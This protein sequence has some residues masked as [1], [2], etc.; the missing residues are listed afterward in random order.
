MFVDRHGRPNQLSHTERTIRSTEEDDCQAMG[1]PFVIF[2]D[3][4]LVIPLNT[5][6][7]SS[8][9]FFGLFLSC[10]PKLCPSAEPPV[11]GGSASGPDGSEL[12]GGLVPVTDG[13]ELAFGGAGAPPIAGGDLGAGGGELVAA[14]DAAG[15]GG[16]LV[17]AAD[18]AGGELVAA[19][20]G[21]VLGRPT[22]DTNPCYGNVNGSYF[23]ISFKNRRRRVRG[24][25]ESGTP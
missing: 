11:D 5:N 2:S 14:A 20:A 1:A 4:F 23:D 3:T 8:A 18:A 6:H 17:A 25:R 22:G 16:E 13:Q 10:M 9:S 15:G 24:V 12:A 7:G 19:E 21:A